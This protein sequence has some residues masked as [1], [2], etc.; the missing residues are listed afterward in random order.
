MLKDAHDLTITTSSAE[1]AAAYGRT[2]ESYLKARLDARDHLTALL[3]A[4]PFLE[5]PEYEE[6]RNELVLRYRGRIEFLRS[7]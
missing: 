7:G 4:D 3:K 6:L 1:A 5:A 2:I